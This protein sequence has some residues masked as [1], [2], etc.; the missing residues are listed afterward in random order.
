M[1]SDKPKCRGESAFKYGFVPLHPMGSNLELG[2]KDY[3]A[4]TRTYRGDVKQLCECDIVVANGRGHRRG[5][6][7]IASVCLTHTV[8]IASTSAEQVDGAPL[9]RGT[10]EQSQLSA[11]S[12][13]A[14]L[15]RVTSNTSRLAQSSIIELGSGTALTKLWV[16]FIK[17]P[18]TAKARRKR[19]EEPIQS[20]KI[21]GF[22][23][24]RTKK[25]YELDRLN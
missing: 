18:I 7:G 25:V 19:T 20:R 5:R 15:L 8:R 16:R 3:E 12:R 10:L 11:S 6:F 17:K 21:K 24:G 14:F 1:P 9:S 4:A 23:P 2:N 13:C 22:R